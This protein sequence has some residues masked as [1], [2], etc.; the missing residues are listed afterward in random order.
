M[1]NFAFLIEILNFEFPFALDPQ[2]V[3]ALLCYNPASRLEQ[4]FQSN[5]S[6]GG[7]CLDLELEEQ[8]VESIVSIE[9][10]L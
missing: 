8:G 4:T 9:S 7:K 2:P 5:F 6:I 10:T 1:L 3:P